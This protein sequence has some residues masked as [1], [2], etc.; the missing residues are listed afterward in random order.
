MRKKRWKCKKA[1]KL[2]LHSKNILNRKWKMKKEIKMLKLFTAWK[3]D[4]RCSFK[5]MKFF[6]GK[7][8]WNSFALNKIKWNTWKRTPCTKFLTYKINQCCEILEKQT[9]K[10]MSSKKNYFNFEKV[11]EI[12]VLFYFR[13]IFVLNAITHRCLECS[14]CM[15]SHRKQRKSTVTFA[16][17]S[18]ADAILFLP[19]WIFF[20]FFTFFHFYLT[21]KKILCIHKMY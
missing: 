5:C 12:R 3:Y 21:R 14:S 6:L 4:T 18:G 19:D 8:L 17:G 9:K 10:M 7:I 2:P 20:F 11:R 16:C 15:Y 13:F 1:E